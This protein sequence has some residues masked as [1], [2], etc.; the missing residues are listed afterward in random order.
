MKEFFDEGWDE[1]RLGDYIKKVGNE[2]LAD[3]Y[4]IK[5]NTMELARVEFLISE[6]YRQ[7]RGPIHK[8]PDA[9]H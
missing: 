1:T 6:T 2:I 9:S 4:S 7:V 5:N 3:P 8:G